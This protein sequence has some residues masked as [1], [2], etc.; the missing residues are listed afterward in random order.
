MVLD[1]ADL[2]AARFNLPWEIARLNE[3]KAEERLKKD[4]GTLF[5]VINQSYNPLCKKFKNNVISVGINNDIKQFAQCE[6]Y[7]DPYFKPVQKSLI[8]KNQ[9]RIRIKTL[10]SRI[11][12]LVMRNEQSEDA[13]EQSASESKTVSKP[14]R[15]SSRPW[16]HKKPYIKPVFSNT[17]IISIMIRSLDANELEN[18]LKICHKLNEKYGARFLISTGPRS[19]ISESFI[20]EQFSKIAGSEVYCYSKM[21]GKDNPYTDMIARADFHM[22]SGTISTTSDLL[23]TG[24]PI[25]YLKWGTEAADKAFFK[26]LRTENM[27]HPFTENCLDRLPNNH[28]IRQRYAEEWVHHADKFV[29]YA[30]KTFQQKMAAKPKL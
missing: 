13:T 24:K 26:M 30:L 12:S 3:A 21:D 2:L 7:F 15:F 4:P 20:E 17:P 14:A 28:A 22:T 10:P 25:F 5:I 8:K 27:V 9:K 1:L 11:N 18:M 29:A 6:I 23:G 19:D 16:K